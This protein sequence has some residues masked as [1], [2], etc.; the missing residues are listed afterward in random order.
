[1]AHQCFAMSSSPDAGKRAFMNDLPNRR[2]ADGLLV[3]CG[4]TNIAS[5]HRRSDDF[6]DPYGFADRLGEMNVG[7]ILNPIHDYMT[8]IRN[9]GEAPPLLARRQDGHLG[10]EP[11]QGQGGYSAVDRLPRRHGADKGRSGIAQAV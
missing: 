5:T 9:A 3:M 10:L 11:G 8:T 2:V 4:E 1:M 7:V 6:S